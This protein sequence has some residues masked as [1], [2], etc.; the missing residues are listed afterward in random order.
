MPSRQIWFDVPPN[1]RHLTE[2]Y[3]R[4]SPIQETRSGRRAHVCIAL[5][6]R[7]L[8]LGLGRRRKG[9][10]GQFHKGIAGRLEG[11]AGAR[12]ELGAGKA[13]RDRAETR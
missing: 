8:R 5:Y 2:P 4:R 7:A 6:V 1:I 11:E 13:Q 9:Q 10:L 3:N 12:R